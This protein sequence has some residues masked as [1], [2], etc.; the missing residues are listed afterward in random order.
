[1]ANNIKLGSAG[2]TTREIDLSGPVT[3]PLVGTPAGVIGTSNK[4][5][6]FVP[7]SVGNRTDFDAK[8]G[9]SD[10]TKFGVLAVYEWLRNAQSVTYLR[11][12]GIGDGQK[13]ST[14]TKPGR[15][16]SAGFIVGEQQPNDDSGILTSNPYANAGGVLGRTYMLGCFMSESAGSSIFS[17]ASLQGQ[18]SVTPSVTMA[19]PILRGVIMAPSGVIMRL[20]SSFT[21]SVAPTSTAVANSDHGTQGSLLGTVRLSSAKQEF[22]LLLNGH[23]GTDS[24]YPNVITAS[25]DPTAPN[26]FANVLN[27]DPYSIQKAGHYLNSFWDIH[28]SLAA[29]TGTGLISSSYSAGLTGGLESAAFLLTGS[30]ARDTGS[31]TV[32]DYE[33]FEDRFHHA[34]SPWVISQRFGGVNKNLF[35][36][37]MLDAGAGT[38]DKIKISIENI[39]P[40]SDTR[41]P[42]GTFD[43]VIRDWEDTDNNPR[44]YE[45]Y[46]GLSL[47]PS[48]DRYIAKAIGDLSVYYD[49]DKTTTSQKLVV[50]GN[51]PNASNY[52]RVVLDD[53]VIN[54]SIDATA[55][56]IGYRGPAH[57][58][59]SG[60]APL[61]APTGIGGLSDLLVLDALKRVVQPPVPYRVSLLEGEGTK[62][63]VNSSLYWG[64]QVEQVTSTTNPNGTSVKN[65]SVK[66][67]TH[68][69]PTFMTTYQNILESNIGQVDTSTLGVIDA[70]RFDNNKFTLENVRVIT[71]SNAVADPQKWT[72]AVYMRGGVIGTSET[73]KTRA[74]TISDFTQ[75]NRKFLKFTMPLQGGFDGV[76]IFNREEANLT[77]TAVKQDMDDSN[78]GQSTGPTAGAYRKALD[79][80]QERTDV[81]IQLLAIPGIRHSIVTD[82]AIDSVENRFDAML[83][84]D[85]DEYDTNGSVITGSV[86]VPSVINTATNFK[87]RALNTSF[88][89]AYYP[90][91]VITDPNTN[92]NV[93]VP[94]S[95]VVL[96][97]FAQNDAVAY[98]WFAPAG[99]SRG[100]LGTTLEAKVKLSKDNMD[101]L[102]DANVNPLVA[103][104]GNTPASS[105]SQGGVVVWGQRTLQ[106]FASSLD[107]VNVRRLLIDLRRQV[108]EIANSF[109]FE[110]NR[111][112][113]LNRFQA[114]VEP[115]LARIQKQFGVERYKVQI[116]TTTTT[117]ADVESNTIRGKIFVQPTRAIEFVSLDFVVSNAGTQI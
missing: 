108:R 77:N 26:Y 57:L 99:F 96:G 47:N 110:P 72:S 114:A 32:P 78:R 101:T 64:L 95:V 18:G 81:D 49:F 82:K 115:R 9:K 3:T 29:V 33:S 102:Y 97:A 105:A 6:A 106:S 36:F 112:S 8:F 23:K 103:F 92:T 45:Q 52:V 80:M 76:N 24:A 86:Q 30:L 58:V 90:D 67:F 71:G 73:D 51:Y 75:P 70:D 111:E 98:P 104:P 113:T 83:I 65:D 34:S 21:G 5:P 68:Y 37:V 22:V 117:Q 19:V 50:D 42:Y 61:A 35:K 116:D 84:M 39:S 54:G 20:S 66:C 28:P 48:A 85:I 27:R 7:T 91:V 40:S 14:S 79:I 93:V 16:V 56:P 55:L 62:A 59:T 46:R 38:A 44:V 53:L 1:M 109:I 89:A 10:G 2:V 31:A 74:V 63:L 100:A 69:Y 41:D 4:G 15:V 13:R 107:R 43:V 11:V 60:T 17:S 25:F 87:S 12:L 88:A 94:P